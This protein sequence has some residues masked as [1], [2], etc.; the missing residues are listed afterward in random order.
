MLERYTK[1][2]D[3]VDEIYKLN[4]SCLTKDENIIY[5]KYLATRN[6]ERILLDYLNINSKSGLHN[7]KKSCIEKVAIWFDL[8][9]Y[10]ES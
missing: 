9:V 1:F 10:K 3:L 7:R 2:I 5:Q 8:E 6:N 4:K